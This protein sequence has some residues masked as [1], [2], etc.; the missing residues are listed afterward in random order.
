M[1]VEVI[2]CLPHRGR[3][4]C[5]RMWFFV[6]AWQ[7]YDIFDKIPMK[8]IRALAYVCVFLLFLCINA[9][10]FQQNYVFLQPEVN[11]NFLIHTLMKKVL[12]VAACMSAALVMSSCKSQESAYRAAYE[13]AKAQE[14]TQVQ[15]TPTEVVQQPVTT[16]PAVQ[17][18]PATAP[19]QNVADAEVRTIKGGYSVIKGVPVK[20]YGVVVGSFSLQA[21]A[22]SLFSTLTQQGW[23]PAV[24]KTNETISGITGWY[25]VVAASYDDKAQAVQ[26]RDQLRANYNG[27]WLLYSK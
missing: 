12:F 23:T 7:I 20:T 6:F 15:T 16:T 26:T 21:N 4:F 1:G 19:V 8:I 3:Y 17:Q 25:R 22:E 9:L 13:K 5:A 14:T 2:E 24:V 27:A 10:S 11:I 18:Q